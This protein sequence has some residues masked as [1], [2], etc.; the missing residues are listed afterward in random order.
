MVSKS[1]NEQ[2]IEALIEKN[3]MSST[4]EE[5]NLSGLNDI[6]AQ[7]SRS[8]Q[9]YWGPSIDMD[10]K[11][12]LDLRHLWVFLNVIQTDILKEYKGKELLQELPRKHSKD[13]DTFGVV[14]SSERLL[15][16]VISS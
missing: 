13:I 12:T 1:T 2:D 10:K 6:V 3:L 7:D 14:K 4:K 15:R 16:S 5:R 9:Y 8:V 11:L